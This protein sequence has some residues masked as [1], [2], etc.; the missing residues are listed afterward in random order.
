MW[1]DEQTDG[2]IERRKEGQTDLN[3]RRTCLRTYPSATLSTAN[4]TWND[5]GSNPSLRGERPATDCLNRGAVQSFEV[6]R[7]M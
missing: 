6:W 2:Q 1:T 5:L 3:S 4:L 7:A